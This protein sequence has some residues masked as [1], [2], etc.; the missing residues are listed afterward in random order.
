MSL[1]I[2]TENAA[3]SPEEGPGTFTP[4]ET[5]KSAAP[6]KE[7][8]TTL[9]E[10]G[11]ETGLLASLLLIC[12]KKPSTVNAFEWIAGIIAEIDKR[13]SAQINQI[14]HHEAFQKLEGTWRGLY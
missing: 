5:A 14:L 4:P 12:G 9:P 7:G 8:K 13:I 2:E 3:S 6:A 1:T 11:R 10:S